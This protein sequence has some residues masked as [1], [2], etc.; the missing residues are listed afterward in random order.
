MNLADIIS[1]PILDT[2]NSK[3]GKNPSELSSEEI[4]D[5]D[6]YLIN[7]LNT[8]EIK[9][10][11]N[12]SCGS[13]GSTKGFLGTMRSLF[14]YENPKFWMLFFISI[15]ILLLFPTFYKLS[16]RQYTHENWDQNYNASWLKKYIFKVALSPEDLSLT[17]I[18]I[19]LFAIVS[20]SIFYF[21]MSKDISRIVENNLEVYLGFIK[22]DPVRKQKFLNALN[23]KIKDNQKAFDDYEIWKNKCNKKY[24]NRSYVYIAVVFAILVAF[25]V[26]QRIIFPYYKFQFNSIFILSAIL[27]MFVFTTELYM[28]NFVFTKIN[29]VGEIEIIYNVLN[30]MSKKMN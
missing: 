6:T 30:G 1:K 11:P 29:I 28:V 26:I 5:L 14:H 18:N 3:L 22:R 13:E 8:I 10:E 23:K 21:V 16:S 2:L 12:T 19:I 4:L 9:W 17:L 27:I 7:Y 20:I 25:L 24:L 15:T